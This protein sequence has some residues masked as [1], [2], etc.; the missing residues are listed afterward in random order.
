MSKIDG[1]LHLHADLTLSLSRVHQIAVLDSGHPWNSMRKQPETMVGKNH[2]RDVVLSSSYIFQIAS[3]S[4]AQL[5]PRI[6]FWKCFSS[7]WSVKKQ[8]HWQLGKYPFVQAGNGIQ[9]PL[10]SVLPLISFTGAVKTSSKLQLQLRC[11]GGLGPNG[12]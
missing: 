4:S 10:L 6:T 11:I 3:T 12:F 2:V 5:T 9:A 7:S 1:S 8:I